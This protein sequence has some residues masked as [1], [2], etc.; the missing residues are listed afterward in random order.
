MMTPGSTSP[1]PQ[2]PSDAEGLVFR[3]AWEAQAFAMTLVLHQRGVF[4]WKEWAGTLAEEIKIAQAA[5]DPDLGTTY[6]HHWLRAL[7]RLLVEKGITTQEALRATAQAWE[8]SARATPH[9]M[10]IVL[11]RSNL[12]E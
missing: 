6:Y 1:L 12:T 5:G 9:G 2:Q 4:T 7:E 10:P 3:E 11:G 8:E